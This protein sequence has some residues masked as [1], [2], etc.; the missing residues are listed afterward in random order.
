MSSVNS[1]SNSPIDAIHIKQEPY[2]PSYFSNSFGLN[3]TLPI[4]IMPSQT[5][6]SPVA[7]LD[8]HQ[9]Q[10]P[11]QSNFQFSHL[12]M[13]LPAHLE[14][15]ADSSRDQFPLE[16]NGIPIPAQKGVG[17]QA[18]GGYSI[19]PLY[20]NSFD[21]DDLDSKG[22]IGLPFD[23]KAKRRASHNAVERRRRDNI[24]ERIFE[25][26]TLL[27]EVHVGTDPTVPKPN[28]GQILKKSVDYVRQ[29][30][31]LVKELVE[32]NKQ[33]A[34]VIQQN[35][36]KKDE[37][38][39]DMLRNNERIK[40]MAQI[41]LNVPNTDH[42]QQQSNSLQQHQHQQQQQ[43]LSQHIPGNQPQF[44]N[45]K[46]A[47]DYSNDPSPNPAPSNIIKLEDSVMHFTGFKLEMLRD[48][49]NNNN[50]FS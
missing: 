50:R 27:P 40:Q 41:L 13:S 22:N 30:Q 45:G 23:R 21:L 39:S 33:L 19:S 36:T 37:A 29:M 47:S 20:S 32:R 14:G 5:L 28:K 31:A 46:F 26:C 42:S 15:L 9:F 11:D 25:L 38:I 7:A 4:S 16:P 44:A 18:A 35:I 6:Q 10:S 17:S 3:P 2:E 43:Q 1:A 49:S 48:L 8:P 24:N 12:S 34:N